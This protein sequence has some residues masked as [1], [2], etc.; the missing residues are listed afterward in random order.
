[1]SFAQAI[2]RAEAISAFLPELLAKVIPAGLPMHTSVRLLGVPVS[3]LSSVELV[4]P[5]AAQM[6]LLEVIAPVDRTHQE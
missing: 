5:E 1:M 3:G 6:N 2:W 4:P